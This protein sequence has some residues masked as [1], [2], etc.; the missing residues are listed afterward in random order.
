MKHIIITSRNIVNSMPDDTKH[1][2]TLHCLVN[3]TD[4]EEMLEN[5]SR[6]ITNSINSVID[7]CNDFFETP[8]GKEYLEIRR[9]IENIGGKQ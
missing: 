8:T 2:F 4:P 1:S 3:R 7:L 6:I 5:I 9:K